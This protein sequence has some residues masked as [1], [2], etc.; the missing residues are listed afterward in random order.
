MDIRDKW[1]RRRSTTISTAALPQYILVP[2]KA[3]DA[4]AG[5]A[6]E[7]RL[8]EGLLIGGRSPSP[9]KHMQHM[10]A[11]AQNVAGAALLALRLSCEAHSRQV[12]RSLR[13]F[14]GLAALCCEPGCMSPDWLLA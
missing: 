12:L 11:A 1:G 13:H 9:S 10:P 14:A 5:N 3:D 6:S 7:G 2:D 4:S 8:S